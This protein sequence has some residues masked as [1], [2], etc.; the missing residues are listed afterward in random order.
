MK[1]SNKEERPVYCTFKLKQILQL[2]LLLGFAFLL[3]ACGQ[4]GPLIPPAHT[5]QV[6]VPT[7]EEGSTDGIL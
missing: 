2:K 5:A 1:L 6:S 7:T 4:K 3:S